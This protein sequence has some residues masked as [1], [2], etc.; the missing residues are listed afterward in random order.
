M[1]SK[2]DRH[3]NRVRVFGSGEENRLAR[4]FVRYS[5]MTV[6]DTDPATRGRMDQLYRQM[7]PGMKLERV[8]DLTQT[9]DRLA[10][11]GLRARHPDEATEVLLLRLARIKLGPDLFDRAYPGALSS[12]AG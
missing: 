7:S 3:R 6:T 9:V 5:D 12:D 2:S 11:A 4:S 8:R 1:R 10:M